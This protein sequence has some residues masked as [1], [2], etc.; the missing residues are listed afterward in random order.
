[1]RSVV[2]HVLVLA[3]EHV[4]GAEAHLERVKRGGNK[5]LDRAGGEAGDEGRANGR[6]WVY[7]FCGA[8]GGRM[9]DAEGLEVGGI[10]DSANTEIC[11]WLSRELST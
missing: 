8:G 1:M 7:T 2:P 6:R 10:E 9:E 3:F 11:Q 5:G 4:A